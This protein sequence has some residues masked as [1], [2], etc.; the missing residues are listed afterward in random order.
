MVASAEALA[1]WGLQ[2][3]DRVRWH[4]TGKRAW[5]EARVT[6]IEADASVACVDADGRARAVV[7]DRL[8][9]WRRSGR[10]GTRR[11]V[12]LLRP[13]QLALFAEPAPSRPVGGGAPPRRRTRR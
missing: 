6:G 7:A 4:P 5:V 8:E 3:D 2:A 12:P 11:W 10:R 9:V 1:A 13:Q